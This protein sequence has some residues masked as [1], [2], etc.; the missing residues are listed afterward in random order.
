MFDIVFHQKV[1]SDLKHIAPSVQKTIRKAIEEKLIASP[2]LFGKPLQFSLKGA[3]S[4]RVGDYR[5]VFQ[6]FGNVVRVIMI[7]HRSTV[8][9]EVEKRIM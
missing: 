1:A 7:G 9:K 6:I 2:K 5:V 4:M 8:Y 3:R